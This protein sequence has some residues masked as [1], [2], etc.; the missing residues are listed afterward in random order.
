MKKEFW[1]KKVDLKKADKEDKK[2]Y[3]SL[4]SEERL[5]IVQELREQWIK[6][7]N[8]DRKRLQRILRIIK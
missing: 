4:S 6:I 5:D 8:E 3:R 2:Y 7:K 1:I